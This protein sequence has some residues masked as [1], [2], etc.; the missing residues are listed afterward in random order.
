MKNKG[1][2]NLNITENLNI[3]GKMVFVPGSLFG[4]GRAK[5]PSHFFNSFFIQVP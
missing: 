5:G 4:S 1:E 3:T 2:R